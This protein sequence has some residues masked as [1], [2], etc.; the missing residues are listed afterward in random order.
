[1]NLHRIL[2]RGRVYGPG[3]PDDAETDDGVER[4][5]VFL[6][7]NANLERQ[8]EFIQQ[9]WSN[10]PKFACLYD[11]QDPLLGTPS[12]QGGTFTMQGSP[13]ARRLKG[14]PSFVTVRGGGYFFLPGLRALG[15][16]SALS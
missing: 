12:T 14:L 11:E 15:A 8:F 9:T 10:N 3:L 5:L 13:F 16:L 1:V 6:A 7:V 4:G 2:R